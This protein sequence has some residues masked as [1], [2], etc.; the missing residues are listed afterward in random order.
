MLPKKQG[1][2]KKNSHK[3]QKVFSL[4]TPWMGIA[5]TVLVISQLPIAIKA[6]LDIV[7]LSQLN[8]KNDPSI[9]WCKN[10]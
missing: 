5:F 10:L 3:K 4:H 9:S 1:P 8:N 6:S 7:C 2:F